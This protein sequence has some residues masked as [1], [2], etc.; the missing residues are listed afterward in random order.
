MGTTTGC[1]VR[2]SRSPIPWLSCRGCI[3]SRREGVAT[4]CQTVHLLYR[5]T[6]QS[7]SW[8]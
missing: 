5:W 1:A 8:H 6:D 3:D 7:G 4:D 2:A